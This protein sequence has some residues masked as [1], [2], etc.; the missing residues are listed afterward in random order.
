MCRREAAEWMITMA[1]NYISRRMEQ[2]TINISDDVVASLVK[3]AIVETEGFGEL[4]SAAGADITDFIGIKMNSKGIKVRFEDN[5]IIIDVVITA[6]YG[7]N[8]VEVSKKVQ[9]SVL[10]SVQSSTGFEDTVVNV[11]VAGI[12]F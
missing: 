10:S 8:I 2:G 12:A 4:A 9:E 6:K 3:S 1:D 11:H 5:R 7:F